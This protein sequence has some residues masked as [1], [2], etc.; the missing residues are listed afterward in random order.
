M[1]PL[2]SQHLR[3]KHEEVLG[4]AEPVL[5]REE[6]REEQLQRQL[7]LDTSRNHHLE[8]EKR[9]AVQKGIQAINRGIDAQ[10]A[11]LIGNTEGLYVVNP[12][13]EGK[14][15]RI[16]E[17]G[18]RSGPAVPGATIVAASPRV[19]VAPPLTSSIFPSSSSSRHKQQQQ[20]G[21]R[22]QGGSTPIGFPLSFDDSGF[23]S[24]LRWAE[25]SYEETVV[26]ALGPGVD[27]AKRRQMEMP[28]R[29]L[30]SVTCY[31]LNEVLLRDP[32][33]RDLWRK[34]RCSLFDA[35]F[36]PNLILVEM[37]KRSAASNAA[38]NGNGRGRKRDGACLLGGEEANWRGGG[39]LDGVPPPPVPRR[40]VEKEPGVLDTVPQRSSVYDNVFDFSS[41][42]MWTEEVQQAKRMNDV[43]RQRVEELKGVVAKSRTVLDMAGRRVDRYRKQ[44]L[45]STWRTYTEHMKRSRRTATLYITNARKRA[46][47][48]ACFLKWRRVPIQEKVTLLQTE[49]ADLKRK[50][51]MAEETHNVEVT[52][53]TTAL[54]N[55]Q[56]TIQDMTLKDE[57]LRNQMLESH[58]VESLGLKTALTT[59]TRNVNLLTNNSRRWER[60]A[61][62]L[63]PTELCR[64]VP[65]QMMTVVLELKHL[66]DEVLRPSAVAGGGVQQHSARAALT[67][68]E[69]LLMKWVN[70]IMQ[71]SPAYRKG[72]VVVGGIARHLSA[73][74][75]S[76]QAA[77][78]SATNTAGPGRSGTLM[79]DILESHDTSL[80]GP[81]SLLCLV[82]ELTRQIPTETP[83][84]SAELLAAQQ[85]QKG[86]GGHT[87]FGIIASHDTELG[88]GVVSGK[89]TTAI[90]LYEELSALLHYYT[91]EGLC[92]SLM[93]SCPFLDVFYSPTGLAALTNPICMVWVLAAL[94]TG[95][96]TSMLVDPMRNCMPKLPYLRCES[97][98]SLAKRPHP[99][100]N[101][102][103][104]ADHLNLAPAV[105]N[106]VAASAYIMS[107]NTILRKNNQSNAQ[108]RR[109]SVQVI[110]PSDSDR[111]SSPSGGAGASEEDATV[112]R[113]L[114]PFRVTN[115][116]ELE[117]VR[118]NIDTASDM[119]VY[120][121]RCEELLP[122]SEEDYDVDDILIDMI[123][124]EDREVQNRR[125]EREEAAAAEEEEED[126]EAMDEA[127]TALSWRPSSTVGGSEAYEDEDADEDE[128][129]EDEETARGQPPK[130]VI[131]SRMPFFWEKD[132][133]DYAG[134]RE[135]LAPFYDLD[136]QMGRERKRHAA[137]A[138]AYLLP[139]QA[140]LLSAGQVQFLHTIP[141]PSKA[142][143]V[144]TH[145]RPRKKKSGSFRQGA[146]QRAAAALA[147]ARRNGLATRRGVSTS[148]NASS[149]SKLTFNDPRRLR[150][151]V[152]QLASHTFLKRL[153]RDYFH[154]QQWAG[155]A[156]LVTSLFVRCRL[157][158]TGSG[159]PTR[160]WEDGSG[161][162]RSPTISRG[163]T[164]LIP[165]PSVSVSGVSGKIGKRHEG[166]GV[167]V[168]NSRHTGGYGKDK[169]SGGVGW[170][171]KEGGEGGHTG[172]STSGSF[173]KKGGRPPKRKSVTDSVAVEGS[174]GGEQ[175]QQ[176]PS[177]DHHG[178]DPMLRTPTQSS[179]SGGGASED[180][181]GLVGDQGRASSATGSGRGRAGLVDV[182]NSSSL[183]GSMNSG[184][185]SG[186]SIGSQ[187]RG[188]VGGSLHSASGGVTSYVQTSSPLKQSQDGLAGEEDVEGSHSSRPFHS[189]P[190]PNHLL[191]GEGE[192]DDGEQREATDANGHPLQQQQ[193]HLP[194]VARQPGNHSGAGGDG[195]EQG[196][197]NSHSGRQVFELS[198]DIRISPPRGGGTDAGDPSGDAGGT[199]TYPPL[200]RN[201]AGDS[202][203]SLSTGVTAQPPRVVVTA[204]GGR[205]AAAR[206]PTDPPTAAVLNLG[207]GL[208]PIPRSSVSMPSMI[209]MVVGTHLT[210]P[211]ASARNANEGEDGVHWSGPNHALDAVILHRSI[212]YRSPASPPHGERFDFSGRGGR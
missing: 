188:G 90:A 13:L 100:I 114:R 189:T 29:L 148:S 99:S 76:S 167:Y 177:D 187:Q 113:R 53:L 104:S 130:R 184:A 166:S 117:Y 45:F 170:S 164:T 84:L 51:Q 203:N 190:S 207:G 123:K 181:T 174:A 192:E 204:Q 206:L 11:E 196:A 38:A 33:V 195:E 31:L 72:W 178:M 210:S 52:K 70:F 126:N 54:R 49:L 202:D 14:P 95:Y 144:L 101:S 151:E 199:S 124:S 205:P 162:S 111:Q 98:K 142:F 109:T 4:K 129:D 173:R 127:M 8:E 94:F 183:H 47:L 74:I 121:G 138:A 201:G 212:A 75:G 65:K 15:Y 20:V 158:D 85:Q 18:S 197:D 102:V 163:G 6:Q 155:V 5:N 153:L 110:A 198:S 131:P 125:K 119:D 208:P 60:L 169:V 30:S 179:A 43:L 56:D 194:S 149:N 118:E 93:Q 48:E 154:R 165:S 42:C 108:S 44:F 141:R 143:D 59:A 152:R 186:S 19:S 128:E 134:L 22:D 12:S 24:V 103:I 73:P 32:N 156:R 182:G 145:P 63:R 34:L 191:F 58:R 175:Q 17:G 91:C 135:I 83:D 67:L 115:M 3:G 81:A 133:E 41:Y 26:V 112:L 105:W 171:M 55:S 157:L 40:A 185:L 122:E 92:Q 28:H 107:N 71:G 159:I 80:F 137:E 16:P 150:L 46:L 176:S 180:P 78:Q 2:C 120:L 64:S 39:F 50:L 106:E 147:Q 25:T 79:S 89:A 200:S 57:A 139:P 132:D 62:T 211:T 21:P 140:D 136:A 172:R 82:R 1:L 7:D 36:S 61:K 86:G 87:T 37:A 161:A 209:P 146:S 66:E 69:Q 193:Q 160:K 77:G 27:T 88:G 10:F 23:H 116:S 97:E 35:V 68:L 168:S 96:V 9:K